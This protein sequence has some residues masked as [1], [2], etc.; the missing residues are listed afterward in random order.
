MMNFVTYDT[1]K[2][3]SY[4][5]VSFG[6]RCLRTPQKDMHGGIQ[7]VMDSFGFAVDREYT[8]VSYGKALFY[9]AFKQRRYRIS[10][11]L[12]KKVMRADT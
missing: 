10:E 2:S 3:N 9:Q 7:M 12:E 8:E 5:R 11:T 1:C 4:T 6:G